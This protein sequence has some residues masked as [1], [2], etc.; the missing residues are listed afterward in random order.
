M[1]KRKRMA[2]FA[3]AAAMVF[4]ALPVNTL[5]VYAYIIRSIL[6]IAATPLLQTARP[7]DTSTPG[8]AIPP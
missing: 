1:K 5:A 6:P 2:A 4:S 8:T 7:A 3:L